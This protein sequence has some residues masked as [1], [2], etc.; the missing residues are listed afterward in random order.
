MIQ[1]LGDHKADLKPR[2]AVFSE[3]DRQPLKNQAKLH[4]IR[5][6]RQIE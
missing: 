6:I 4:K 1:E 3:D 5:R 2:A